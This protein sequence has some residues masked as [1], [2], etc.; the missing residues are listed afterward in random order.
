MCKA[1]APDGA[2]ISACLPPHCGLFSAD[3]LS[4]GTYTTTSRFSRPGE[5]CTS[6][7]TFCRWRQKLLR[8]PPDN[9]PVTW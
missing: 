2:A 5:R 4:G 1:I 7:K 8:L 6:H 3:G 9:Y